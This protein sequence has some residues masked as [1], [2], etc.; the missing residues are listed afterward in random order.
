MPTVEGP[1][2]DSRDERGQV[3]GIEGVVFG[4]LVFMIGLLVVV[5]AWSVIDTKLAA[6]SAARE[7]TRAFVESTDPL[8]AA[9]SARAAAAE[10]MRGR[11]RE[12]ESMTIDFGSSRLRR[13]APVTVTVRY[14]VRI[15]AI[16]VLG[17]AAGT[18]TVAGKHSEVVD[19][20]RSGL[21]DTDQCPLGL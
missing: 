5:N 1:E 19:P 17:R 3:G 13:C 4:V 10:V 9:G 6:S 8:A 15:I 7:G 14:P 16:P 2:R 21:P 20:Y 11:G 12:T 18:I